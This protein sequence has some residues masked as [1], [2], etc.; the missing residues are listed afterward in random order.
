MRK[1]EWTDERGRKFISMLED[2]EADK[3]AP[4]G[5]FVGPPDILD[6]LGLPEDVTT[7]LHNQLYQRKMWTLK[8]IQRSPQQLLAA[9]QSAL[10]IDAQ[11]IMTLYADYEKPAN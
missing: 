2:F 6:D 4:D 7:R 10:N 11:R 8:D 9:L 3:N 5:V 1:V